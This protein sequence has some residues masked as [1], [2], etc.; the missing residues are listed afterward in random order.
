M[1]TEERLTQAMRYLAETDSEAAEL[2]TNV[3]RQAYA[4][5]KTKALIYLHADGKNIEEKKAIAETS[6]EVTKATMDYLDAHQES[7]AL[8]NKRKTEELITKIWQSLNAN[9]RQGTVI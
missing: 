4:V 2:K 6:D 8:E 1:I 7:L 3:E 5:K 9:R